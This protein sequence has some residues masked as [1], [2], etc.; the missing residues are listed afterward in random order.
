M[1]AYIMNQITDELGF[2]LKESVYQ[3]ALAVELRFQGY[4]VD[5]RV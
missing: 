5:Y 1:L 3:N 4:K 2:G